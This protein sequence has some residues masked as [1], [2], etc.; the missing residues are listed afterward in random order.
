MHRAA[1]CS[2]PDE[3]ASLEALRE[4]AQP[5]AVS[6]EDLYAIPTPAAKYKELTRK[7]IIG[8]LGLHEPREPIEPIAQIRDAAREPYTCAVGQSDH[9]VAANTSRSMPASTIPRT[10]TMPLA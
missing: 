2:R 9:R 5:I 1:R 10:R 7:C 8:E 6:P 3:A 4:E